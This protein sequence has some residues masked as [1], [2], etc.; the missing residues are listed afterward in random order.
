MNWKQYKYFNQLFTEGETSAELLK[1]SFAQRAKEMNY[2]VENKKTVNKTELYDKFYQKE[3]SEK[4]DQYNQFIEKYKFTDTNFDEK[5]FESLIKIEM[6][7]EQILDENKSIK[8]ISTLYFDSA[9]YLKKKSRIFEVI[10]KILDITELPVDEHDQQ[11]LYV[12]HCKNKIP[13]AI[14][15]CE[16]DNQLRKERLNDIELWY[17][18]G[19]N[20]AKLKYIIEP[21]IP[22]YYLCDWDNRGIEIYQ[23]IKKN[24]F[25]SIEILVPQEPIKLLDIESEWKTKIDFS[26]F[27][28]DAQKLLKKLIPKKWIEEESIKHKLLKR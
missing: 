16:N 12:L 9:K 24:I 28:E 18:G 2:I 4:F 14:I 19:R 7:K 10:L 15:L 17:A 22:F 11:Y 8:E 21:T 27:S 20:T 6:N 25:P 26:L 13:K 1:C 23:D 5:Q 3:I